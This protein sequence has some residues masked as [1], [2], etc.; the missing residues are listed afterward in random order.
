RDCIRIVSQFVREDLIVVLAEERR[1]AAYG[2]GSVRKLEG[3]AEHLQLADAGML[4][5]LDH[6]PRSGMGI[7]E[8]LG[9]RVDPAAGD[10]HRLE[11]A[12][13]ALSRVA[14]KRGV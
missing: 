5:A 3:D 10:P 8:R 7:I 11:L 14:G 2:A 6:A 9:N 4:D 1:R 13:P 12:Q